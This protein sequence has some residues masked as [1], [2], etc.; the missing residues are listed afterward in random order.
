MKLYNG[1]EKLRFGTPEDGVP[2]RQMFVK[3]PRREAL[4]AMPQAA[5]TTPAPEAIRFTVTSRGCRLEIP[6]APGEDVFPQPPRSN[7]TAQ[8]A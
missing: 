5:N 1:I 6:L 8:T 4:E 3:P 2:S 7:R